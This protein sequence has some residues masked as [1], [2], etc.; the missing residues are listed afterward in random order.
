MTRLLLLLSAAVAFAQPPFAPFGVILRDAPTKVTKTV[1]P[2]SL[3]SITPTAPELQ[4]LA[5]VTVTMRYQAADPFRPLATFPAPD[6][7]GLWAVV[8]KDAPLG[9]FWVTLFRGDVTYT[10]FAIIQRTAPGLFAARSTFGTAL[11]LTYGNGSPS[12][13]ALTSA[14]VPGRF[15]ALFATGLNDARAGDVTLDI[16]GQTVPASYAG[17]QATPGV[18]QIN[19]VVPLDAYLGCYVPVT[20]RVR[21]VASNAVSL[22]IN[23][24]PFA[25]AHPL[26]LSY[27]EM[28]TLDAGGAIPF[29]ELTAVALRRDAQLVGESFRLFFTAADATA[30]ALS[31][32]Y[33]VPDSVRLGCTTSA[34][35]AAGGFARN[36]FP[37]GGPIVLS[38]PR[39]QETELQ[40]PYSTPLPSLPAPFYS[41]G[42]WRI[43]ASD[44]PV[45]RAFERSFPLPAVIDSIN[46]AP[47]GTV[48]SEQELEILWNADVFGPSDLVVVTGSGATCTTE[49]WR[50][51]VALPKPLRPSVSGEVTVTLVPHP[52]GRTLF[53]LPMQDGTTIP[54]M[55]GY[56][57]WLAV[58]FQVR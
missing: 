9:D 56:Y 30:I 6:G 52:A 49:G 58:S 19:F 46:I 29:A 12:R 24:D 37:T 57:F 18:D 17:P 2:G 22:P 4:S 32:G 28:K 45:F 5:G 7:V 50:G 44:G 33:Q 54:G 47:G 36:L 41:P 51:R 48:S 27:S 53:R 15:V 34:S 35:G 20:I 55:A 16:A 23:G 43:R 13:L 1:A 3:I 42:E 10:D 40:P 14:A 25:C 21:G 26:G 8:P 11:A 31:A 39:G 38:G